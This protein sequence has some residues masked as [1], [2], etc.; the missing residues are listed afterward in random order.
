LGPEATG[1]D[2]CSQVIAPVA[3]PVLWMDKMAREDASYTALE[4]DT[5]HTILYMICLPW[6]IHECTVSYCVPVVVDKGYSETRLDQHFDEL[7]V[8]SSQHTPKP[9][10]LAAGPFFAPRMTH[11]SPRCTRRA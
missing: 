5:V 3:V 11:R 7:S 4:C 2:L 9:P 6:S 1:T 8:D 10:S